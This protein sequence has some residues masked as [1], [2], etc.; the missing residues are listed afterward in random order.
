MRPIL[1]ASG[2]GGGGGG[3]DG[4]GDGGGGDGSGDGA[5]MEGKTGEERLRKKADVVRETPSPKL[6]LGTS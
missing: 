2:G 4:S 5:E 3:S 6:C 1:V